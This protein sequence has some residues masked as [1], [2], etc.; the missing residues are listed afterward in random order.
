MIV[1]NRGLVRP[2]LNNKAYIR[3]LAVPVQLDC[4]EGAK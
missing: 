1:L 3:L 2:S 4:R